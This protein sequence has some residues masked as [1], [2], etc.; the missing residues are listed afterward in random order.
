MKII[1]RIT[2]NRFSTSI[3]N[4]CGAM[5]VLI[6]VMFTILLI[7][8]AFSVDVAYMQ[9]SR[10]ELRAATD[11]AARAGTEALSR[12]QSESAAR[13]AAINIA[14]ENKVAGIPLVITNADITLGQT[15]INPSGVWNFNSGLTPENALRVSGERTSS[16]ASG[17]ISL[18]F[19]GMFGIYDYEPVQVAVASQLD[20][21]IAIVVDRSGSMGS[22]NRWSGLSDAMDVFLTEINNTEQTEYVSLSSYST[23]PANNQNLTADTSL[24]TSAFS[25]LYP[26]GWTNIGGGLVMGTNSLKND[27]L[28]RPYAAKTIILMTDGWHNIGT[29]P[30]NAAN[31]AV[32]RNHTVH[33]IAFGAGANSALMED[34]ANQT[35]GK[36]FQP[37]TNQ[38][39]IDTFREIA[40]TLPVILTE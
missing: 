17:P 11:A 4:R 21:D 31:I 23:Y 14:A 10:T 38:E 6:A 25:T 18:F 8:L 19:G 39:L 13:A 24:I 37:L 40:L 9:L 1:Q 26:S 16:S 28:S 5:I 15:A 12:L 20:R 36:F 2:D 22:N 7:T 27:L 29:P 32:N 33:T 30:Y 35:G 34:I 3:K